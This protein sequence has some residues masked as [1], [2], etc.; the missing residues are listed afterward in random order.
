MAHQL[1]LSNMKYL[2]LIKILTI[3][4][5]SLTVTPMLLGFFIPS[6]PICYAL[7]LFIGGIIVNNIKKPAQ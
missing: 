1:E 7:S 6:L 4:A 5:L 3:L 2:R